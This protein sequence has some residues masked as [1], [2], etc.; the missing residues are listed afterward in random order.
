MRRLCLIPAKGASTRLKRKN[1]RKILGEPLVGLVIKKALRSNLFND[2][3]VSTED[4]EIAKVSTDYGAK[5][6]FLREFDM[7]KDPSTIV[8]VMIDSIKRLQI[9]GSEYDSVTVLLPTSPLLLVEDIIAASKLYDQEKSAVVMSVCVT[10]FPPFNA[11]LVDDQDFLK[12]C[13]PDS[14]YKYEKSTGCPKTY[15][16]NGALLICE[17]QSFMEKKSYREERIKP[18]MMPL[19]RS[20]DIDTEFDLYVAKYLASEDR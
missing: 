1:L 12:P 6:P 5:V 9:S 16:S 8:D 18:Y 19:E 11:W 3:V 20:I 4:S 17:V 10:E 7:A 14:K 2:I 13:F 15:R